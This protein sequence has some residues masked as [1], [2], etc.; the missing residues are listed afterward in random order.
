MHINCREFGKSNCNRTHTHS[1]ANIVLFY[2]RAFPISVRTIS[3]RLVHF[4]VSIIYSILHWWQKK[5]QNVRKMLCSI[6]NNF[7]FTCNRCNC[8]CNYIW[9]S[10]NRN[11]PQTNYSW[12]NFKHVLLINDYQTSTHT[13]KSHVCAYVLWRYSR[14]EKKMIN[15][16]L[17]KLRTETNDGYDHYSQ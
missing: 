15:G 5:R 13:F 9:E 4:G 14:Y 16:R 7:I 3:W 6:S 2:T 11:T 17:L 10:L 1:H 12:D 8:I